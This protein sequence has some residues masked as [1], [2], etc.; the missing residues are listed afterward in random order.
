[1]MSEAFGLDDLR[2][3]S[4]LQLALSFRLPQAT[5]FDKYFSHFMVSYDERI[6]CRDAC[7]LNQVCAMLHLDDRGYSKCLRG[8]S[9]QDS[10]VL[11]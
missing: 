4:L 1:M 10:N 11:L 6:R 2:P 7:K 9:L 3:Q 5:S 8:R